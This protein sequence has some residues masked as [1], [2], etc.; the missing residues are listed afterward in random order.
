M[1]WKHFIV[2]QLQS[3]HNHETGSPMNYNWNWHI[4]WEASP[5]GIGTYFDTL[6]SGLY[7]T[8]AVALSAW[9]MALVLGAIVGT[10]RTTPNRLAARFANAYVELFRNIPLLVQMFLWYFVMPELLPVGIGNW[11]KS[12]PNAAF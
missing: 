9:I 12:L 8:L 2:L 6:L 7:W 4:F 3:P 10:I 1:D 5:E 11:L